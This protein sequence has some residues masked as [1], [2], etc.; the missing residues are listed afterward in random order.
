MAANEAVNQ[1]AT[2]LLVVGGNG[3]LGSAVCKAAVQRG[4][5]VVSLSRSGVSPSSAPWTKAVDWQK[6]DA[7]D[8]AT[9]M[10]TLSDTTAVVH[11][12]GTLLEGSGYKGM[13]KSGF[14]HLQSAKHSST[15]ETANRDTALAV[16][17][18]A[19]ALGAVK[20]EIC[21]HFSCRGSAHG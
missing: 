20:V 18:T 15:Y 5:Q 3:F 8:P 10:N 17:S 14:S 4:L 13:L 21:L 12:V 6:G 1:M 9:Y 11:T 7:L 2:K 19:E 16:A